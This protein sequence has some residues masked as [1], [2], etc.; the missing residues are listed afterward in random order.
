LDCTVEGTDVV[1]ATIATGV[2]AVDLVAT[3]AEDGAQ[4]IEL[5]CDNGSA[6]LQATSLF[7]TELRSAPSSAG[8]PIAGSDLGDPPSVPVLWTSN[9]GAAC[10]LTASAS[11]VG[12][13]NLAPSFDA[14]QEAGGAFT[15]TLNLYSSTAV[16]VSC[17]LPDV[18]SGA[19]SASLA[20]EVSTVLQVFDGRVLA[21]NQAGCASATGC[22]EFVWRAPGAAVCT[23]VGDETVD[24]CSAGSI[25]SC[26]A[27]DVEQA[28]PKSYR[29]S[30][31][32]TG[33]TV[34]SDS[35]VGVRW[36]DADA[37][38]FPSA[39]VNLLSGTLSIGGGLAEEVYAALALREVGE[40]SVTNGANNAFALSFP[41]LRR[42][43]T[44]F[45]I[46]SADGLFWLNDTD[47]SV[48]NE[49][50]AFPLLAEV[51]GSMT[52]DNNPDLWVVVFPQ[53]Q[54]VGGSL[55]VIGNADLTTL[56][57]D[58]LQSVGGSLSVSGNGNLTT[59]TMDS[60]QSVG[61]D[62]LVANNNLALGMTVSELR[63]VGGSLTIRGNTGLDTLALPALIDVHGVD[64]GRDFEVS[65]NAMACAVLEPFFCG[66][67][68]SVR[69]GD[70][71]ESQ[72]VLDDD[73][74]PFSSQC[75]KTCP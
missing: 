19:A 29:L 50:F 75:N 17:S 14:P 48:P 72:I 24:V 60:L 2:N 69:D 37:D 49:G 9:A 8:A 1:S 35:T 58:S 11:F 34:V 10:E 63:T 43:A 25:D 67:P 7:V 57:M 54:T 71:D 31:Q 68:T 3:L 45:S 26:L 13:Q 70:L 20:V 64:T 52:V 4:T 23:V 65:D 55:S 62:L 32:G 61:G 66:L 15:A 5:S 36:G 33:G 22:V 27:S 56:T 42:V 40:L 41:A 39:D 74:D 30:C 16:E 47:T 44:D 73:D 18:G 53:L 6:T 12:D 38:D 21:Q 28:T 46:A 59:L 51:G